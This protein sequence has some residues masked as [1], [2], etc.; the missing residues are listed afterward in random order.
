MP[1]PQYLTGKKA[2]IESFLERFDVRTDPKIG[3]A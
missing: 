2:E 1:S 3:L